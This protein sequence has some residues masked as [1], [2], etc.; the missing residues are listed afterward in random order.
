MSDNYDM[1]FNMILTN[2]NTSY[3]DNPPTEEIIEQR[4]EMVRALLAP[5]YSVTDDE[6]KSIRIKLPQLIIHSIGEAETLVSRDGTHKFGWYSKN[7]KNHYFWDRY[8]RYLKDKPTWSNPVINRLDITTDEIMDFLGDPQSEEM[9]QRRGLLLGD[10][11][12]G[13][14]ATYTS[15]CNKAADAGYKVIIV[16]AGSLNNLRIQTQERLD[17][18][19]VGMD[20][21]Y[22]LDKNAEGRGRRT[23][24][25]DFRAKRQ[26]SKSEFL[27]GS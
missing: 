8:Y 5:A 7:V 2:I 10:V 27:D 23:G 4:A 25:G 9:F 20:S 19:F 17:A 16:L 18:E 26:D 11:Q 15:I 14:T 1:L 21:R 13:K 6:F 24:T 12:S 22:S 3:P